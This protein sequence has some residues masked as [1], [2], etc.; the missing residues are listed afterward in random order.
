[1]APMF[2][3]GNAPREQSAPERMS[4]EDR[5][6]SPK[7]P[8]AWT[9][10]LLT[11]LLAVGL[12]GTTVWFVGRQNARATARFE[13]SVARKLLDRGQPMEA[14]EHLAGFEVGT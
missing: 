6:P 10:G 8:R 14:L 13:L 3:Q 4:S 11:A 7:R 12:V 9:W 1:M 2:E 5:A